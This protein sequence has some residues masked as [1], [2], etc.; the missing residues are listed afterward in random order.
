MDKVVWLQNNYV[1]SIL[2]QQQLVHSTL[3]QMEDVKE[4]M[5]QQMHL[6]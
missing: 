4:A 3:D 6:A 2:E 1:N 5:I